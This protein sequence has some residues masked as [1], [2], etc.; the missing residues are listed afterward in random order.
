LGTRSELVLPGR[1]QGCVAGA[2][3]GVGC[4]GALVWGVRGGQGRG[5]RSPARSRPSDRQEQADAHQRRQ[6]AGGQD[7]GRGHEDAPLARGWQGEIIPD[8]LPMA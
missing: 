2:G 6:E 3:D 5:R 8:G 4:W 1:T 7:P